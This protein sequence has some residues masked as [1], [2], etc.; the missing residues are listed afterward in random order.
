MKVLYAI[1]GTGNGHLSRSMD[2]VPRLQQM[3]E[4]DV[5]VSG[6]Q[7]DLK[8]P[9]PVKYKF[10]GMGFIFGKSGGVDLWRTFYK[11]NF[12]K[13]LKEVNQLPVEEYDLVLCD[14]EPV[15]AWA[16][17]LKNKT[18]IGLS[19]QSAVLA[20]NVPKADSD[21]MIGKLIL[22]QYAPVTEQYGFHFK[23][24][25]GN[26][27]TPVIRKQVR[28]QLVENRGHYTVYLPA[29]DDDKLIEKLSK[30]KQVQWDVFSKHNKKAFKHKHISIQPINNEEFIHSMATSAGVLCGAGF[31]TP[32]EA[33]FMKKKLLVI[34]MKNQYEQQLNA[35]ALKSMGVTVIK[36][37]KAKHDEVITNWLQNGQVIQ[38]NY[39]D[40]TQQVLDTIFARH[41]AKQPLLVQ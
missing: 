4:V 25:A 10:H 34:P 3:A 30:F 37:L 21:D 26:I 2:I 23:S 12:R 38:V 22:K 15:S 33:L 8:L 40:Q 11:S 13:F 14:F 27:Y 9:F 29:F 19:H 31:E 28:E 18:C 17:Y 39:P 7:G 24:F 20:Q 35:A 1:Q 6:I 16:C 5:V 36:S 32:A 41:A